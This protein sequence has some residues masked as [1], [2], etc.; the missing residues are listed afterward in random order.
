MIGSLDLLGKKKK[1]QLIHRNVIICNF[2][3]ALVASVIFFLIDLRA[4]VCGR[5]GNI[6]V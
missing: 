2:Y 6:F 3:K 5:S 4:I 1:C